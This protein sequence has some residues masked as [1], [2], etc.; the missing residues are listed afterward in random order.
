MRRVYHGIALVIMVLGFVSLWKSGDMETFR[1]CVL[2]GMLF[3][4]YAKVD[5]TDG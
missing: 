5:D 2:S 1:F 4:I 3:N